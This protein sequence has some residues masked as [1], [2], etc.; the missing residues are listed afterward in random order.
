MKSGGSKVIACVLGT[1]IL[2]PLSSGGYHMGVDKHFI[3]QCSWIILV[4]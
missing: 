1:G 4:G 3:S 2:I